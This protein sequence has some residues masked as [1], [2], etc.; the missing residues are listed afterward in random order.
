MPRAFFEQHV[1]PSYQEWLRHPSDKRL[2][3][4]AVQEVNNLAAHVFLYWKERDP[5]EVYGAVRE[6]DYRKELAA[7]ECADFALARDVAEA[8]KHAEL[9]RTPR[10][11][12]R[13]DQTAAPG[14]GR[15]SYGKGPY[16]GQLV[17][18][19]DDGT[20]RPLTEIMKNVIDMWER[21]L[22]RWML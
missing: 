13:Y 7:R 17:V 6:G 15:G 3:K 8:H 20:D 4:S 2:A 5:S 18:T 11:V 1:M 19:L 12:T 9:T 16:G 22:E 21:L 10:L 14:W